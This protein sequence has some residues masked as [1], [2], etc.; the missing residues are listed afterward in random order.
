[1]LG[2]KSRDKV[3]KNYCLYVSDQANANECFG[4]FKFSES[5]DCRFHCEFISAFAGDRPFV[6]FAMI[7]TTGSFLRNR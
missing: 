1:M 4:D 6:L 7:A 2:M 5:G 3:T